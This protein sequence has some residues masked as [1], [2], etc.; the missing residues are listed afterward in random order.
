MLPEYK[1]PADDTEAAV[2]AQHGNAPKAWMFKGEETMHPYWAIPRVTQADVQKSTISGEPME[3]NMEL[4]DKRFQTVVVGNVADEGLKLVIAVDVPFLVNAHRLK[5]KAALHVLTAP[6][7]ESKKRPMNWKDDVAA[8]ARKASA[9]PTPSK[10]K[11][12]SLADEAI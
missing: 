11:D 5:P 1:T 9:K 6:K 12:K 2:V 7:P 10:A 3:I 8:Q 4:S